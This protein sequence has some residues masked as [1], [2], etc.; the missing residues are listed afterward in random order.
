MTSEIKVTGVGCRIDVVPPSQS[1]N[2]HLGIGRNTYEQ[3]SPVATYVGKNGGGE[4]SENHTTMEHN[5]YHTVKI[6]KEGT[7]VKFYFNG[8]LL[9]TDTTYA[10]AWLGNY[11][12]ESVKFTT[13]RTNTIYMRNLSVKP[14]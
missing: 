6:V 5:V 7:T 3:G 14:L 10:Q 8:T 4:V 1:L 2:Y 11:D 12:T 13:W 9:R